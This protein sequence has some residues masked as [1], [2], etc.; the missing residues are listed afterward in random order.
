MK[1]VGKAVIGSLVALPVAY[2]LSVY[3][4]GKMIYVLLN[5]YKYSTVFKL[6]STR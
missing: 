5:C 2:L 1:L 6:I 4:L 3:Q